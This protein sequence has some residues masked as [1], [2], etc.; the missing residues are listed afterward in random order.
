[1]RR[2]R[3]FRREKLLLTAPHRPFAEIAQEV[4]APLLRYLERYTGNRE[5]AGDLRQETLLRMARGLAG[6]AGHSS[7]K[8]WAFAIANR[9]AADYFRDPE[10]RRPM[11]DLDNLGDLGDLGELPSPEA[12]IEQRLI[13]DEMNACI[14][15]TIDRLPDNDRAAL[16]L[17]DLEE[18]SLEQTAEICGC[19]VGA[20]KVRIHR[21][22][23]RLKQA[24]QRQCAFYRDE[25]GEFRCDRK[26]QGDP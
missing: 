20:I 25:A 21:A 24:L 4:S 15:Q 1:M 6:F 14:R 18:L 12:G 13:V 22:R 11:V 23:Q 2:D 8:T 19:S 5:L 7:V 26:A 9:V 10:R 16:V 3:R 17:F